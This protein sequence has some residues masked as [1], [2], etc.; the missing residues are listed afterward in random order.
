MVNI[1]QA[2]EIEKYKKQLA[3]QNQEKLNKVIAEVISKLDYNV[4]TIVRD[5]LKKNE[6]IKTNN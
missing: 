6:S 5:E 1:K 4:R 3:K 2:L